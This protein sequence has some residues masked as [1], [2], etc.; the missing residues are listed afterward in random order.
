PL[1][2]IHLYSTLQYEFLPGGNIQYVYIFSVVALLILII[3]CINFMNLTTARSANRAR[4]VGIRKVLGTEKKELVIQFLIESTLMVVLS[5]VIAIA[6]AYLVL[7]LFNDVAD[8][9]MALHSLFSPIIL[10]LLIALP[11]VVGLL[12][13]SYPAFYLSSFKPIEVL[14][15]KL[16]MGSKS[17]GLRSVLVVIQFFTSIVLIISTIVI[18]RQLHYIQTK[19]LGY[20][21]NQVLIINGAYALENNLAPFRNDL[22]QMHGVTSVTVSGFLPVSSNRSDNT[23]SSSPVMDEKNGIDMQTWAIDYDYIK[24]LGM[25]IIKGRDFSKDFVSDSSAVIINET[26]AKLLGF[27]EPVGKN[28]YGTYNSAS[29]QRI[30]YNIIGV[31]RNFNYESLKQNV[32]PLSLFLRPSTGLVSIK[33]TGANIPDVLKQ[34][35]NKWK[36]MAPGM[37]FSYRFLD[38][39]FNEMYRSEQRIGKIILIFSTLAIL[40]ACLGL[41]GLSTFIAEQRTK[42]IG[43]RKV[44]G[45]SVQGLVQLLSKDFIKLVAISFVIAAPLAWW[46]MS[47]WLQDFAYRVDISWWI[48]LLAGVLA[49]VIAIATVSFQAIKAA[50]MN[51]VTS[52]RTE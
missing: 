48:F 51:P 18:Y 11:F 5:L 12:A 47:K 44:L 22:L 7:P 8:K 41:F 23:W 13:G 14:K 27:D 21:K 32:G 6:I 46:F 25:Q 19:N 39:S 38:E 52:L 4:E 17:G 49:F 36:A 42:E 2:K 40:I 30:P 9:T 45:A 29:N 31:V 26:T 50:L 37:P 3:A 20:D 24:T 16:K 28:I 34:A 35:E 10:P 1:T 33:I 43:I 15:G